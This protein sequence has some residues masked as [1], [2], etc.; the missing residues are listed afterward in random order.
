MDYLLKKDM[1]TLGLDP[2][3]LD[4]ISVKEARTAY[5][6]IS[7]EVHPDKAGIESTARF[8]EVGN[9]YQ[10]IL[11]YIIKSSRQTLK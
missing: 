10:R 7:K 4:I 1:V 5:H 8:Q 11:K 2:I 9:S 6:Q 3:N